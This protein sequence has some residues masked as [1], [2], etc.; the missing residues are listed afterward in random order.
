MIV[1]YGD[2]AYDKAFIQSFQQKFKCIQYNAFLSIT[3]AIRGA[4][5]E[6]I[7]SELELELLHGRNCCINYV[8]FIKHE[9][10]FIQMKVCFKKCAQYSSSNS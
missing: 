10:V 1:D 4:S 8:F 5:R 7:Y 9:I 3:G 2:I 6:K